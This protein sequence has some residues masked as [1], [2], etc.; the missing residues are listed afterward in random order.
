MVFF[1]RGMLDATSM[2]FAKVAIQL[3][4]VCGRALEP[5]LVRLQG[6]PGPGL[7]FGHVSAST[8]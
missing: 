8:C 7:D 5:R 6:S 1:Q 3:S 2:L 4:S